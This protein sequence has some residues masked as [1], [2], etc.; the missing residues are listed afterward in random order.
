MNQ[1]LGAASVFLSRSGLNLPLNPAIW[2]TIESGERMLVAVNTRDLDAEGEVSEKNAFLVNRRGVMPLELTAIGKYD[3][4]TIEGEEALKKIAS[5]FGIDKLNYQNDF[6]FLKAKVKAAHLGFL[7]NGYWLEQDRYSLSR[8]VDSLGLAPVL[9]VIA[10]QEDAGLIKHITETIFS[11]PFHAKDRKLY[12]SRVMLLDPRV[13]GKVRLGELDE[14]GMI[15]FG[16]ILIE[17]YG[18]D[19]VRFM[20]ELDEA[21]MKVVKTHLDRFG[22]S[23]ENLGKRVLERV[24]LESSVFQEFPGS[25]RKSLVCAETVDEAIGAEERF[26]R[27][28][29][30]LLADRASKKWAHL[31]VSKYVREVVRTQRDDVGVLQFLSKFKEPL[32]ISGLEWDL[33]AWAGNGACEAVG[34]LVRDPEYLVPFMTCHL[35]GKL[36]PAPGAITMP[37][38]GDRIELWDLLG[39]VLVQAEQEAKEKRAGKSQAR[40]MNLT[41]WRFDQRLTLTPLLVMLEQ[42]PKTMQMPD[43]LI[44]ERAVGQG[45]STGLVVPLVGQALRLKPSVLKMLEAKQKE[46]GV[47]MH[48][49]QAFMDPEWNG[50][51]LP[52]LKAFVE[53]VPEGFNALTVMLRKSVGTDVLAKVSVKVVEATC[54]HVV[55]GLYDLQYVDLLAELIEHHG[56]SLA[57]PLLKRLLVTVLYRDAMRQEGEVID[58]M[59]MRRFSAAVHEALRF[60]QALPTLKIALDDADD[61]IS[62]E[63]VQES[64]E[65]TLAMVGEDL[66]DQADDDLLFYLP[67]E[68]NPTGVDVGSIGI[69]EAIESL[70]WQTNGHYLPAYG[71]LLMIISYLYPSDQS[72]S[73]DLLNSFR[74]VIS[75]LDT[76][77]TLTLL[78]RSQIRDEVSPILLTRLVELDFLVPPVA[79]SLLAN[80]AFRLNPFEALLGLQYDAPGLQQLVVREEAKYPVFDG[81]QA[82]SMQ[83]RLR[84]GNDLPSKSMLRL[85]F[86]QDREKVRF[87]D[88]KAAFSDTLL[89]HLFAISAVNEAKFTEAK[90]LTNGNVALAFKLVQLCGAFNGHIPMALMLDVLVEHAE[91]ISKAAEFV[92]TVLLA[93]RQQID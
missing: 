18:D 55:S 31:K 68:A 83:L 3:V 22:N 90:T 5:A 82:L 20:M 79:D 87:W 92:K 19:W 65:I 32:D 64:N 30:R 53:D 2:A 12:K 62:H 43:E 36:D 25:L 54:K 1:N 78:H 26:F 80:P 56:K 91:S 6:Q 24:Y 23:R 57:A 21:G 48:L 75:R 46:T 45:N 10:G 39:T 40:V 61:A 69:R 35:L 93:V 84:A 16:R 86:D 49:R 33:K 9:N 28:A 63:D 51:A 67:G 41:Y 4:E 77:Q 58:P 15:A 66:L 59:S 70:V 27:V 7:P 13:K 74:W 11:S 85:M 37:A 14:K 73:A 17:A 34:R 52:T 72:Y 89:A 71:P 44:V 81:L 29:N 47:K 38:F 8:V 88:L 76:A 42:N 50:L 60:L